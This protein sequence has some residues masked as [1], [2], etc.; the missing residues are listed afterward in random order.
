MGKGHTT[1]IILLFI[2]IIIRLINGAFSLKKRQTGLEYKQKSGLYSVGI[3]SANTKI[4][5]HTQEKELF[6]CVQ[7]CGAHAVNSLIIGTQN[8]THNGSDSPLK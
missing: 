8:I 7:L 3:S 6:V 5:R 4:T 2:S 1:I